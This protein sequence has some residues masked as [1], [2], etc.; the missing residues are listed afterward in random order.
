MEKKNIK[1]NPY[2]LIVLYLILYVRAVIARI[3]LKRML[4]D[5]DSSVNILFVL[6]MT[7]S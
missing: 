7:R 6:P 2:R 5:I 3:V 1:P 4:E